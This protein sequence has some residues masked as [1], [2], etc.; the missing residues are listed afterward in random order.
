MNSVK[1]YNWL[2]VVEGCSVVSCVVGSLVSV[3]S[4][5]LM[6]AS[7]PLA[8]ALSL[9][10][11]NRS[12]FQQQIRQYN[13]TTVSEMHDSLNSLHDRIQQLP[14]QT[15]DF[16]S[17]RKS[18][19]QLQQTTRTLS[20]QFNTR[21]ETQEVK[22]LKTEMTELTNL[23]NTLSRPFDNFPT[24]TEVDTSEI[25]RTLSNFGSQLNTLTTQVNAKPEIQAIEELK[26]ALNEIKNGTETQVKVLEAQLQAFD[27]NQI[28]SDIAILQNQINY[29]SQQEEKAL[30]FDPNYLE[31]RLTEIERKNSSTQQDD[32]DHLVSAIQQLQSEQA[33]T[34]TAIANMTSQLD[35]L[36]TGLDN[37]LVPPLQVDMHEIQTSITTLDNQLNALAQNFLARSEPAAIQSLFEIV[38]RLQEDFNNLPLSAGSLEFNELNKVVT[39]VHERLVVLE[40]LNIATISHHLSQLETDLK[41][42]FEQLDHQ[43][44]FQSSV[45]ELSSAQVEELKQEVEKL[46]FQILSNLTS[47][48]EQLQ[49]QEQVLNHQASTN[50]KH[51]ENLDA[52]VINLQNENDR[53]RQDVDKYN[54]ELDKVNLLLNKQNQNTIQIKQQL[55]T[56]QQLVNGFNERTNSSQNIDEVQERLDFLQHLMTEYVKT[57]YLENVLLD[58]CEEFSKQIDRVVDLQL[59][60]MNQQLKVIKPGE[61]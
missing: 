20:E 32:I 44:L 6:Y 43:R 37:Q 18:L 13:K 14:T 29:I 24:Y 59:A 39:G 3:V 28:N 41:S 48:I 25:E 42:A 2:Q 46:E 47:T 34:E 40:S 38:N 51:L 12:K 10:L 58:L 26:E 31:E 5:Q 17:I 33:V 1:Q 15:G 35:T 60:E 61:K 8:V 30:S 19:H 9:N 53:L 16:D 50:Q 23:F 57:E 54:T 36:K 27:L 49:Q 4:Q 45:L 11:I 56:L 21:P 55:E 52:N 7:V 22:Q